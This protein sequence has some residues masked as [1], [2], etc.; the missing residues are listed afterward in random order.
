MKVNACNVRKAITVMRME[1]AK[2][3]ARIAKNAKMEIFASNVN[4]GISELF[5]I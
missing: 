4:Q 3:A 2:N 5:R 1:S